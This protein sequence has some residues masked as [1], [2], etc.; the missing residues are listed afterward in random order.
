MTQVMTKLK[1][2]IVSGVLLL[3]KPA[4]I[5]SQQAVAKV[6]FLLQSVNH[7]SKKAG[8]TGTL[9]PM[10]TGLLPICLG[11]ATKFSHY[12]LC[13]HKSYE[14]IIKLG[15][16]TDTA[17]KEG[18]VIDTQA[19]PVIT[20]ADLQRV[21]QF[22]LGKSEQ[23]P[24][25]YSALKKD[26]K[27]LYELARAGIEIERTSRPIEIF[28]LKLH[29]LDD[30]HIQL[31][32]HCSK[33]TYVRVLGED[34]AQKLATVGHL[35]ALRRLST[36]DFDIKQAISLTDFKK[37]PLDKRLACLQPM[38]ACVQHLAKLILPDDLVIRVR[39]GQKLN[40]HQFAKDMLGTLTSTQDIRL[41]GTQAQFIGIASL[42]KSGRLQPSKII[43]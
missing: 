26:G 33:G 2:N 38:D 42:E 15:E 21:A 41:Y 4:G 28:S 24:P 32:V 30:A 29:K 36:G 17:D 5:S 12:Q 43:G 10:A 1:Q 11:Y 20:Q 34:I 39:H 23:I 22:F 27:K 25:M 8:H 9:D 3:D 13:A 18:I 6:K 40:V 16:K 35:I 14:A 19:I 37:L 7:N 31:N